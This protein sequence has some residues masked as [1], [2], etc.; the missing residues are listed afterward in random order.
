MHFCRNCK[1]LLTKTFCDLGE[2]PPSNSYLKNPDD[3]ES[4]FPLHAYVCESCLLVQLGAF[5]TPSEIFRD[6]A[7]FSSYSSSW[8][9]HAQKYVEQMI[10]RFSLNLDSFVVEIAS[11]DGYLLQHFRNQNI[12][13]LGVEPA[14]NIAKCAEEKGIRTI[15]EFFGRGLA[16]ELVQKFQKADLIA[17]NNVLAHVPDLDDFVGGFTELLSSEGVITFEFPHLQKLMSENQ[18]DTIYHEHFSYFSLISVEKV[19]K[20]QGLV[21]FDAEKLPTHGGSLRIFVCHEGSSHVISKRTLDLKQEEIKFGLN[22]LSTY[23][24]FD[25]QA[26]KIREDLR[27]L[28]QNIKSEG[29]TVCGYGAPAKGNTLLNYCGI[30][31]DLVSFTVDLNPH[32]Q[33][34]FLPG[35]HIPIYSPSAIFDY[36]PDYI[37]ILPWNLKTEILEQ[38]SEEITW[39]VQFLIPI[40]QV[41]CVKFAGFF[42]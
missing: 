13:H 30:D 18:F 29:K 32:K 9:E 37:L 39:D 4:Y 31:K 20:K 5:Q 34:L 25:K 17:A 2:T 35:S 40:P 1:A 3:K 7:Y 26:G 23:L 28:L 21:V 14:Q 33:G 41:Q 38:L 15:S 27:S 6:Y 36:R 8:V 11:N 22:D 42:L 12:P 19:L 10:S 24:S 16:K